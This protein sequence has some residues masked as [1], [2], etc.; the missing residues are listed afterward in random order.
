MLAMARGAS[1]AKGAYFLSVT[2]LGSMAGM[3]IG[4]HLSDIHGRRKIMTI[5]MFASTPL[6]Y[7]FL[8]TSG[9]V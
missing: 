1:Y 8:Y 6:L 2:I 9:I 5:A 7:G 4:G 3:F